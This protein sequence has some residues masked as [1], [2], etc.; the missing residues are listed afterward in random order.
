METSKNPREPQYPDITPL[1]GKI[2]TIPGDTNPN[3][4][5]V[6]EA[7]ETG[8]HPERLTSMILPEPFDEVAYK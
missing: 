1:L 6:A 4:K 7:F 8:R 5:S 3:T 2:K